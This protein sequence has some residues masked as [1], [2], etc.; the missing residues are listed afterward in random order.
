MKENF[1]KE[2]LLLLYLDL[3]AVVSDV[4]N[5]FSIFEHTEDLEHHCSSYEICFFPFIH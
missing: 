1:W 2:E 5:Y 4:S 3:A